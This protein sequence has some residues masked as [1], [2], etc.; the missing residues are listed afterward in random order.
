MAKILLVEDDKMISRML[1]M[2]LTIEGHEIEHAENGQI[3]VEKAL[4][5]AHDLVLMDMHMPVMDGHE[6]VKILRDNNYRTT[7]VAV[8]ASVMNKDTKKAIDA[9][10]NY[11][12]SKPVSE[13][14]EQQ[15]ADILTKE[16]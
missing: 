14:F 12:I 7:I 15:I 9:G 4:A 1:T 13:S 5:G 2:R 8:T 3:G 16:Q 6:A 11:F 10:C